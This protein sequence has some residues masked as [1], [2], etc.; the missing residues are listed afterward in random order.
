MN[1]KLYKPTSEEYKN[2]PITSLYNE[3]EPKPHRG[4]H[5]HPKQTAD[6]KLSTKDYCS[7]KTAN[8]LPVITTN[9]YHSTKKTKYKTKENYSSTLA[10]QSITSGRFHKAQSTRFSLVLGNFLFPITL[11]RTSHKIFFKICSSVL[12]YLIASTPNMI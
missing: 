3:A 8:R 11:V 12:Q 4:L 5:K 10:Q 1:K 2:N 6:T 9:N 7:I